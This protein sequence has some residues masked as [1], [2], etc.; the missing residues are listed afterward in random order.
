MNKQFTHPNYD[1]NKLQHSIIEVIQSVPL[2]S[3]ATVNKDGTSHI[4]TAYFCFDED[5]NFYFLTPP[6]SRHSL[7]L[8]NNNSIAVTVF[9]TDQSWGGGPMQGIQ[10]F[11]T[12]KLTDPDNETLAYNTYGKRFAA[13]LEWMNSMTVEEKSKVES[14]FYCLTPTSLKLFD[15][16]TFGEETFITINL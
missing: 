12:A 13:F 9:S 11:G 1:S 16:K 6:T 10:I 3:M 8:L 4:N 7:N 2:W 14:K 5:F 15:E